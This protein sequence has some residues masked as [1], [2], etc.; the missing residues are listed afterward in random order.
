MPLL[1]I[2]NFEPVAQVYIWKLEETAGQLLGGI[3]LHDSDREKYETLNHPEKKREFLGLRHCL[4]LHF[5]ENPP[6]FYQKN[7]KPYLDNDLKVSFSH[8]NGYSAVIISDRQEVGLDLELYRPGI[9]KVARKYLREDESK[10]LREESAVEHLLA[11]WG[12][13]EV[14]VKVTGNRR[15]DFKKE[16]RIKPFSYLPFQKIS[17]SILNNGIETPVRVF[18]CEVGELYV[19][20]GWE[21]DW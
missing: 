11:Y 12:A 8:T 9:K 17:G 13:K 19:T 3:K 2:L 15:L 7:G 6:V 5:G 4:K 1:K 21:V 16:L 18:S 14:M 20:L 10:T